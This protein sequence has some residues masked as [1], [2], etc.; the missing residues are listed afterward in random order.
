MQLAGID[1]PVEPVEHGD[2]AG[3]RRPAAQ[4]RARSTACERAGLEP[5]RPWQD[6]LADYMERAGLLA[7]VAA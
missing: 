2:P 1:V 7:A 5:L 6:A 3:R 4:R